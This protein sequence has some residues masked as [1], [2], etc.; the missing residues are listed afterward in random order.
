[1]LTKT[2][3]TEWNLVMKVKLQAWQLWNA[4]RYGDADLHEDRRALEA[5]LAVVP[6]EMASTLANKQNTKDA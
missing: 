2:N 3:F 6:I 1:M 5:L 4:V